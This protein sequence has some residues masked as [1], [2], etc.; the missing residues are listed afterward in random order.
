MV[1]P[2]DIAGKAEETA[3][4][5]EEEEKEEE[6]E[7][8]LGNLFMKTDNDNSKASSKSTLLWIKKLTC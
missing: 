1:N 5:E 7:D 4:E 3:E 6:E 8:P 2:R